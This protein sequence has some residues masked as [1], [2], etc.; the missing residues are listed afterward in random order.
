MVS[1]ISTLEKAASVYSVLVGISMLALWILLISTSSVEEFDTRPIEIV[2]HIAA[3]SI[4]GILLLTG[5]LMMWRAYRLRYPIYFMSLG[6][7]FYTSIVSPGYYADK[8][9]WPVVAAFGA[10][11]L[12]G[13]AL[14]VLLLFKNPKN[15]EGSG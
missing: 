10:I 4:T 13:I 11:L 5:G 9:E 1:G 15:T 14:T 8:G 6:M 7:L 2:L 12:A 3:E